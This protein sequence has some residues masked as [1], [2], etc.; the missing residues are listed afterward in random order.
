MSLSWFSKY[1][2]K[3]TLPKN[4]STSSISISFKLLLN[5]PEI[6]LPFLH[7]SSTNLRNPLFHRINYYL[8]LSANA[9]LRNK[10]TSSLTWEDY[11]RFFSLRLWV[12]LSRSSLSSSLSWPSNPK[13][14]WNRFSQLY[15]WLKLSSKRQ[16]A[17]RYLWSQLLSFSKAHRSKWECRLS[18]WSRHLILWRLTAKNCKYS[19]ILLSLNPLKS[20]LTSKILLLW[21]SNPCKSSWNN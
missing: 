9:W 18:A 20:L 3:V 15:L 21:R 14:R 1:L 5:R 16:L 7:L 4:L 2:R 10:G 8:N 12:V 6:T 13:M 11:C 17:L 19:T